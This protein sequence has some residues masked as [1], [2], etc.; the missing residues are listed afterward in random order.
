MWKEKHILSA[1]EA[2]NLIYRIMEIDL[3]QFED[4]VLYPPDCSTAHWIHG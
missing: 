2:N 3:L 1:K 4:F